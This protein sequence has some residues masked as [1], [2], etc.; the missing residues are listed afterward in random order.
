MLTTTRGAEDGHTVR[1]YL[2]GRDYDI[3]GTPRADELARIFV[4]EGWAETTQAHKPQSEVPH[5]AADVPSGDR[6]VKKKGR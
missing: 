3:G 2:A 4:R 1:E 6:P 5:P